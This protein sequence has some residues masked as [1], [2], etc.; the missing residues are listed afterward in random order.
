[1]GLGPASI[2]CVSALSSVA[3]EDLGALGRYFPRNTAPFSEVIAAAALARPSSKAATSAPAF[4]WL[5]YDSFAGHNSKLLA[6]PGSLR[7]PSFSKSQTRSATQEA[8]F[9]LDL[10]LHS[11]GS[12]VLLSTTK[13]P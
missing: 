7:Y 5:A 10:T 1:M 11:C 12:D 13:D 6:S 8:L 9:V 3:G 4:H 2:S